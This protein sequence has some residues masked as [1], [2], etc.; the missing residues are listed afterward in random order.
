MDILAEYQKSAM[1]TMNPSLSQEQQLAVLGLGIAGE[2]GEVLDIVVF[3]STKAKEKM[4]NELGDSA[5]YIGN[6]YTYLKETWRFPIELTNYKPRDEAILTLAAKAS[7][8]AAKIADD[9][10]K[11]VGQGHPINRK[12]IIELLSTLTF[13]IIYIGQRYDLTLEEILVNNTNKLA[14]RYPTKFEAEKSINR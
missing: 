5:W 6:T 9:I 13:Y 2:V 4:K 7:V 1:R 14:K 8:V 12:E 3:P 10:K 11:S